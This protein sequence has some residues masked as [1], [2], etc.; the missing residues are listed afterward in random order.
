MT[1]SMISDLSHIHT[2]FYPIQKGDLR[3]NH[4][5]LTQAS[6][7]GYLTFERLKKNHT[8]NYPVQMGKLW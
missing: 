3:A 1:K 5:F 4:K 7:E 2:M 8:N 6:I